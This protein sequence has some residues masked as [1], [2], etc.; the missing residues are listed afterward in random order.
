MKHV[1]FG[2]QTVHK[3]TKNVYETLFVSLQLQKHG[4]GAKLRDHVQ[5][6]KRGH[7]LYLSYSQNKIGL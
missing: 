3:H 4:D 7:D 2:M 5:Q 6:I 1:T